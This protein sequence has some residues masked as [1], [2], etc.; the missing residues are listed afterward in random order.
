MEAKFA[1]RSRHSELREVT[2]MTARDHVSRS[3]TSRRKFLTASVASVF[4]TRGAAATTK[5]MRGIFI[6]MA[7]PYTAAKS[8]D[9]EDLS[10]E[11]DFLDRCGVQG[12]VWPQ[13]ASEYQYL[14]KEERLHG[15]RVLG[16]AAK[17]KRPALVL[18]V[19]APNTDLALEYARAA[20]QCEPDAMI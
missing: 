11:V 20:E 2:G 17:G 1:R 14:T 19:Q 18:G 15:M 8:V 5:R 6:I 12:I 3:Q 16:Q 9:F 13:F 10:H 4:A 7:T